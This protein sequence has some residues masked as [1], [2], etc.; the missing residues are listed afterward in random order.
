M[1][2]AFEAWK[3]EQSRGAFLPATKRSRLALEP[4]ISGEAAVSLGHKRIKALN[5]AIEKMGKRYELHKEFHDTMIRTCLPHIYQESFETSRDLILEAHKLTAATYK[6]LCLI[7]APR[8]FGKTTSVSA[9]VAAYLFCVPNSSVVIFSSTRR[10]SSEMTA[11]IVTNLHRIGAQIDTLNSET[12]IVRGSSIG[13]CRRL[14][15]LPSS[16]SGTKGQGGNLVILEEA[17]LITRRML[18]EV[19]SPL[20]RVQNTAFIAISTPIADSMFT[21]LL[22]KK[23]EQTG[24]LLFNV[25][26]IEL[27]C[28]ECMK[29]K[30]MTCPHLAHR[31]PPWLRGENRDNVVKALMGD[32]VDSGLYAQEILGI[33]G[34]DP[35]RVFDEALLDRFLNTATTT[36][37]R[38][39][40]HLFISIDPSGGGR[41]RFAIM[42]AVFYPAT[43]S[44]VILSAEAW[45]VRND[46]E[47]EQVIPLYVQSVM[48]AH[49]FKPG[50][51]NLYSIIERN[52]G[53]GVLS[54][55]IARLLSRT[56]PVRHF[57]PDGQK[58]GVWTCANSKERMRIS[59]SEILLTNRIS[60]HQNF[61]SRQGPALRDKLVS[62]LK[63][64][65]YIHREQ[66][67]DFQASRR[68]LTG[69]IAGRNDDLAITAMILVYWG[70]IVLR[71]P[72]HLT[73]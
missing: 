2:A 68:V 31:I 4:K 16:V 17:A 71:F 26:K 35:S 5:E 40:D 45:D 36:P 42:T 7:Q 8:R 38:D 47:L 23:D 70:P 27:M 56:F 54:S 65:R 28:S 41:S 55:H 53:G 37:V 66:T 64:Y 52:Y 32:G 34:L 13:D 3:Q 12:V 63:S 29:N 67:N 50:K 14:K 33:S 59:F 69:K 30:R 10:A 11:K 9:Y 21:Q 49:G 1:L 6:V 25:H 73:F 48:T 39:H 51:R 57:R 43:S 19:I 22:D 62:E 20:I 60:F 46:Q 72:N 15:S 58:I 44:F 18:Q 61:V 24:E